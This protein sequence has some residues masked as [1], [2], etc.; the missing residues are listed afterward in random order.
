M[1]IL[2][3]MILAAHFQKNKLIS[4]LLIKCSSF[5]ASRRGAAEKERRGDGGGGGRGGGAGAVL[6]GWG[7]RR[8]LLV[9]GDVPERGRRPLPQLRAQLPR[10]APLHRRA[11]RIHLALETGTQQGPDIEKYT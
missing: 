1:V 3:T 4:K 7:E 2:L 6:F 9:A 10:A 5:P 8:R 11:H